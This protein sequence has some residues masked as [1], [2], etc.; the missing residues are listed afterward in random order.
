MHPDHCTDL[1]ENRRIGEFWE[2]QFCK[3]ARQYGHVYTPH[4]FGK[5]RIAACA[6]T[7][8][9]PIILPDITIWSG[10]GAHHEIKHKDPAKHYR[11][12]LEVYR[13]ESLLA[14][15]K[16][17][18]EPVYYTI[19]NWRAMGRNHK[20]NRLCDWV[21]CN[22]HRLNEERSK[23]ELGPSWVNGKVMEVDILYWPLYLFKPLANLWQIADS[24]N[25]DTDD[26][27]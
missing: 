8:S 7:S 24:T 11:F 13:L 12:G 23:P 19:H 10:D 3:L 9:R 18:G 16:I 27:D 1:E 15:A 20:Y 14:F 2:Q 17:T 21:T 26:D 5:D 6:F 4:Q 25:D 22:V